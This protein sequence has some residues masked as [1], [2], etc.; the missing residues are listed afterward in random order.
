MQACCAELQGN[1]SLMQGR[2]KAAKNV[3]L[4]STR[5]GTGT[6]RHVVAFE[7][8]GMG[9]EREKGSGQAGVFIGNNGTG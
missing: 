7:G 3:R 5:G 2:S 6:D 8:Q 1:Q 9:L 4:K